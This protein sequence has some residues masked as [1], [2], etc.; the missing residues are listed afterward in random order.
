MPE[1]NGR[2]FSNAFYWMEM[3]ECL[4]NVFEYDGDKPLPQPAL[5]ETDATSRY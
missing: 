4:A 2:R 3:F 5:T 1:H